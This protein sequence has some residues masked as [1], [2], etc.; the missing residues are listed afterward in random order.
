M[1][2]A[3]TPVRSAF[4][5]QMGLH[6]AGAVLIGLVGAVHLLV[7]HSPFTEP[8]PPQEQ[9]IADLAAATPS[10]LVEGWRPVT[11]HDFNTGTSALAGMFGTMFM[12]LVV[13]AA[14]RAPGLVGR[15]SLFSLGCLVTS[16]SVLW[17]GFEYFPEPIIVF[18][19][20]ATVCFALVW[21]VP[22]RTA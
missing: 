13:L 7:F 5:W 22:F 1:S 10:P 12:V 8:L 16:T 14:R 3:A 11:V 18:S 9:V 15:W 4:R 19:G 21:A 6:Y 2:A 17:M 20:L